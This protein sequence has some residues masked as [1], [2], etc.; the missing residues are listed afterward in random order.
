MQ[1]EILKEWS[2]YFL[3]VF[4]YIDKNYNDHFNFD[5]KIDMFDVD[6]QGK[7]FLHPAKLLRDHPYL[8]SDS[9]PTKKNIEKFIKAHSTNNKLNI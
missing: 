8:Q 9:Y 3:V 5:V 2:S 7:L 6:Y 1:E 4:G